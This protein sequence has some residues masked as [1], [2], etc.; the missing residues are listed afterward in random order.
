V[1]DI[2]GKLDGASS[3]DGRI[4]GSYVHGLFGADGFRSAWLEGFGRSSDLRYGESIEAT[5]DA[6][7]DHCE[8][9]LDI[10]QI[11]AIARSR[12]Q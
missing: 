2:A 6:L 9:H 12:G 8:Q 5:L 11:I 3:A 1:L 10:E 7:A 4:A